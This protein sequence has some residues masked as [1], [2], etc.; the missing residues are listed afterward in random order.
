MPLKFPTE[1]HLELIKNNKMRVIP[2]PDAVRGLRKPY[3]DML[4][5]IC[6]AN[7][8]GHLP[9]RREL[10]ASFNI[11][12]PEVR[13]RLDH[14]VAQGLVTDP[15]NVE[16]IKAYHEFRRNRLMVPERIKLLLKS[17]ALFSRQARFSASSR[18]R[19]LSDMFS[20]PRGPGRINLHLALVNFY[21]VHLPRRVFGDA[22]EMVGLYDKGAGNRGADNRPVVNRALASHYR[23][24]ARKHLKEI[25]LR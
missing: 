9:T 12:D 16:V 10:S 24:E 17:A 3:A 8:E 11:P 18:S 20:T 4:K 23:E 25:G 19:R 22:G 5:A 13:S 21:G 7:L 1:T 14:L 2:F 15:T 6:Q